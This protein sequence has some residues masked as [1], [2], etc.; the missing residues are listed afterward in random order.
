MQFLRE[1]EWALR[2]FFALLLGGAIGLERERKDLPAGLR[3]F[4]LVS[5]GSCL[6]TILSFAAFPGSET[7]RVAAQVVVGISFIG[8]GTVLRIGGEAS[9]EVKGLTTAAG[10]WATA[11][12]GMAV[13]VGYYWLAVAAT[14]LAYTTLALLKRLEQ[15]LL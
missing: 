3:T 15:R 4:M 12:I 6:F 11:A 7:S 5:L 2:L 8:A 9:R 1:G 13:A 14:I 10:L